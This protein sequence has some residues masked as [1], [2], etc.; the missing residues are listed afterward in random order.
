MF[1]GTTS[2]GADLPGASGDRQHRSRLLRCRRL[3]ARRRNRLA[4]GRR[5]WAGDNLTIQ[6]AFT[7]NKT[8]SA[9]NHGNP[10]DEN[11]Q[12]LGRVSDRLWTDGAVPTSLRRQRRDYFCTA[13]SGNPAGGDPNDQPAGSSGNPC[14]RHAPDQHRRYRGQDRPHVR[15]RCRRQL[16]ELLP[17]RRVGPVHDGSSMRCHRSGSRMHY[18]V[19]GSGP[20]QLLG[21]VRG[22][23]VDHHRRS[24]GLHADGAQQRNRRFPGSSALSS[25]LVERRFLGCLGTGGALQRHRPELAQPSSLPRRAHWPAS[26]AATS[27]SSP[28]RSTGI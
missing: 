9:A 13:G 22:R 19:V 16:R 11:A 10:G 23:F 25:V 27:A 17:R 8:G 18:G 15:G 12:L 4:E 26:P 21:L 6:P 24:E 2:S 1:E 20:S 7:G 5:I 3:A 28:S 14:R